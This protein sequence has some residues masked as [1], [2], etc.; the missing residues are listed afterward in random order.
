MSTLDRRFHDR[1]LELAASALDFDLTGSEAAELESHLAACP[2]CARSS[3]SMRIDALALRSPA[4]LLPSRRV[5]EAV[6]RAI[7][8]RRAPSSSRMLVLVAATALLLVALLGVAAAGA[9]LQRTRPPVVV[10][11]SP[12]VPAVVVVNPSPSTAPAPSEAPA[13]QTPTPTP[14]TQPPSA[15]PSPSPS[16]LPTAVPA[17]LPVASGSVRLAPG[18][19][20]GLYVVV[21]GAPAGSVVALLDASGA[22]RTGG[23]VTLAGWNCDA[24]TGEPFLPLV[25]SDGSL[26]L[27][28]SSEAAPGGLQTG[29][30]FAFD[31]SGAL[32]PGW[33]VDLLDDTSEQPRV[34]GT[35]L[36]VAAHESS[37]QAPYAGASWLD[38]V[39]ADGTVETGTRYEIASDAAAWPVVIGPDGIAYR[40]SLDEV[41]A[42]DMSGLRPGWPVKP[43]GSLSALAFDT[44]GRV[45]VAVSDG[46]GTSRLVTLDRDGT[47]VRTSSSLPIVGSSPWS[48]AGP[49]GYPMAPLVAAD[50]TAF[51]IGETDG[52]ATVYRV[53]PSGAVPAGWPYGAATTWQW[54]GSCPSG[55]TGCGVWRARPALGPDGVLYL[56]LSAPDP[57]I[58]GSLVAI[59]PDGRVL[60]G[61]P[62]HLVGRGSEFWSVVVGSD[63]TVFA[64]A[65]EPS[66]GGATS[67]TLLA[68]AKDGTVR[69]RSTLVDPKVAK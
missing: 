38:T 64:L 68:I 3:R 10:L 52:R 30:A 1:A 5:D 53:D 46:A 51:L 47:V 42:F 18:P 2:T 61:W 15:A 31:P 21:N 60:P 50:G 62:I 28:C 48:G 6:Y 63:G 25:A 22:P 27:V 24:A 69:W 66:V 49:D 57:Q 56:P 40:R 20:G 17:S 4:G 41:A 29:S 16:A 8:G 43:G 65:V 11:P 59:G 12:S 23:P 58:G 44:A 45:V 7:A 39:S 34:V 36:V 37:T 19:D 54:Q 33:P 32:L 35:R 13:P 9:L 55:T 67:A 26:R 14:T